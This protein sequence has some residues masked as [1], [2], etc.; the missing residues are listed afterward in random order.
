MRVAVLSGGVGGARFVRGLVEAL[1]ARDVTVV[2]NV[3]DDLEVLGLC[4]SPDLDSILYALAG[5]NDEERGWGRAG[6]T[7]HALETVAVLGG[8]SWFRL[9]DRDLGLH[10]VRTQ[11]LRTGE[12]LSAVTR[13][14][15]AALGIEAAILPATDDALR[16]W[17]DTPAGS[18]PFQ[19]WFVARGHRDDVDGV[20]FVGEAAAA[21]G[22]VEALRDADAILLAPSNPYVSIW[23]ILA[24][25]GV[26]EA[27]A[28]RRVPCVAVSP[29]VGGR[30]VKGPADRMLARMAG[31]TTPAHVASCYDGLIDALVVDESDPTAELAVRRVVT[32]TLMTDLAAS[33]RLA[34]TVLEALRDADAILI[35]PSNPYVSIWPILAVDGV[36]EALAARRVPCVAV[37]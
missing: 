19:E 14:L 31:G 29:L 27:L 15:A 18:F 1:P 9:G 20:R 17:I 33:R 4:V 16:T 13:R 21:P 25:A 5:L 23:P 24:V 6:E 37:S 3:G 2:G 8:E 7:W 22:V 28:A 34:E 10:L 12:P 26:R 11:A 30:A 35:A 36:R 32:R